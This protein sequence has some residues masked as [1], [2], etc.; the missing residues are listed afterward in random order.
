MIIALLLSLFFGSPESVLMN[1][2]FKKH[3]RKHVEDKTRKH[4]I[5]DLTKAFE[6]EA[7]SQQKKEKKKVK[8]MN[9][10]NT[11]RTTTVE[12][13]E[14]FFDM[15]MN[16]K[17]ELARSRLVLRLAIQDQIEKLEWELLLADSKEIWGKNS[18]KRKK[19][20]NKLNKSFEKV[21]TRIRDNV[22]DEGRLQKALEIVETFRSEL[23][24]IQKVYDALNIS[25]N[26]V[27][28]NKDA[29]EEE[30]QTI[31]NDII[32]L[33]SEVYSSYIQTHMELVKVVS[34][35]EWPAIIKSIN[36]IF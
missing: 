15:L 3:V 5:L 25:E 32:D 2:K 30:L 12:E 7:K 9:D 17:M 8:E 36:N 34:E 1:P 19:Y 14:D 26:P 4:E 11:S 10:L 31:Q 16:D 13:F 21:E 33:R 35:D 18:K 28:Q 29:S 23:I 6:K 22:S 20:I 24:R 27:Y